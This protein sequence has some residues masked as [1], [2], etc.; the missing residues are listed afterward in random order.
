MSVLNELE[1]EQLTNEGIK[2]I[3]PKRCSPKCEPCSPNQAC[4]PDYSCT[5][6]RGCSPENDSVDKGSKPRPLL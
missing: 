5:P 1:F 6:D 2:E 3:P 4:Y